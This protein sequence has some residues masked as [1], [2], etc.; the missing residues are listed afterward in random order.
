MKV[1][2]VNVEDESVID[3]GGGYDDDDVKLLTKG[4]VYNGLFYTSMDSPYFFIVES[5]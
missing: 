4:F 1:K 3:Y 2:K 5:D